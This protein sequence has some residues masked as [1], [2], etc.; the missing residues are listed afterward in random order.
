MITEHLF[1]LS[2]YADDDEADTPSHF[3]FNMSLEIARYYMRRI[4]LLE[5]IRKVDPTISCMSYISADGD[6]FYSTN[7]EH[8]TGP[9]EDSICA[10][11]ESPR[12]HVDREGIWWTCFH[13]ESGNELT[14]GKVELY[15]LENLA[16]GVY[17]MTVPN[18]FGDGGIA[19]AMQTLAGGIAPMAQAYAGP[20]APLP[21]PLLFQVGA[22]GEPQFTPIVAA[23]QEAVTPW[24]EEEIQPQ[25]E[26]HPEEQHD[27]AGES[28]DSDNDSDNDNGGP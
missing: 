25:A 18:A 9:E 26:E 1:H 15:M 17:P 11:M 8:P 28:E 4:A 3:F 13:A 23:P 22:L 12:V 10:S 20:L 24:V 19:Q 27:S 2:A 16:N 6:Y 21:S 5:T 14:T 7:G